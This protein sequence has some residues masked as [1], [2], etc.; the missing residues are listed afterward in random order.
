M[1]RPDSITEH[2]LERL[3]VCVHR[4]TSLDSTSAYLKRAVQPLLRLGVPFEGLAALADSQTAG[5]GRMGRSWYSPAAEGLYFSILFKPAL[6]PTSLSVLTLAC[7]VAVYEA[8]DC[9]TN[10]L[11]IKWPNDLLARGRKVCGIL[12]EAGFEQDA[13]AYALVGIGVN[14]NQTDFPDGL[15]A[16]SIRLTTGQVVDR[17]GFL[18]RLLQSIDLW[19]GLLERDPK[20]I[21]RA[22][23]TR[24]SYV[25]GKEILFQHNSRM[26]S[27]VT[28][29]LE[30]TGGLNVVLD[31]GTSTTLYAG[32]V[33]SKG[34]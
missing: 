25:E 33:F 12:C 14:L 26:V 28:R 3:S 13:L 8:L 15:A 6:E 10:E 1:N 4:F 11:D 20:T 19:Y 30:A 9:Y 7:A 18:E 24:S 16:T 5:R 32:E 34:E 29:G 21:L 17:E 23:S 31:D 2:R 27:G 22:W